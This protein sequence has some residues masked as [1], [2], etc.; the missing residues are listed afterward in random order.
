MID[1]V[2]KNEITMST[3]Y[4]ERKG[5]YQDG[6]CIVGS[7]PVAHYLSKTTEALGGE[8]PLFSS[9]TD[10]QGN[11]SR[12]WYVIEAENYSAD[13]LDAAIS[14]AE[15][16]QA[17]FLC[18]ILLPNIKQ[19]ER[20]GFSTYGTGKNLCLYLCKTEQPISD[21]GKNQLL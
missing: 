14:S 11:F 4:I 15:Q 17:E 20:A 1:S 13:E 3:A 8:V 10:V 19:N 16:Q 12:L 5:L 6:V 2:I 7:H 21:S 9:V 18:I